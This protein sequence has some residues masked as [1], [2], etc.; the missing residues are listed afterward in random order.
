MN[1]DL[2]A[3][4][5]EAGVQEVENNAEVNQEDKIAQL[6]KALN[7]ERTLRKKYEKQ[8]LEDK[9]T[10]EAEIKLAED[11]IRKRLKEGKSDLSDDVVDD[12]MNTFGK[13]L[14]K[15]EVKNARREVEREI[16][17]LKRNPMYIDADEHGKEIRKLMKEGLSAEQAYWATV[18]SSK[19]TA[20]MN[21]QANASEA[22]EKARMNKERAN[23]GYVSGV[24]VGNE[25]K[26]TYTEKERAIASA[27]GMS[28][29]EV[30]AR[31]SSFTIDSILANNQ[32]FKK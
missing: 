18:G 15:N 6:T 21:K 5:T 27:T 7:A 23:Q 16:L 11:D 1:E 31:N 25:A 8:M 24:S 28:A 14:A 3:I 4:G 26:P 13:T 17:E 12:L 10:E 20:E 19:L 9:A 32:K 22:E 29:E 2:E 30:K